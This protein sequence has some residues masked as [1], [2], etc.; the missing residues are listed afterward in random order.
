LVG[1]DLPKRADAKQN[2]SER[3]PLTAALSLDRERE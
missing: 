2:L 1:A 3:N